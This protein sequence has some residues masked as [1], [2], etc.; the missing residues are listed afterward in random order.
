[1]IAVED[2]KQLIQ[3]VEAA[4]SAN[5]LL[6]TVETLA[7][8]RHEAAI[9]TLIAILGYNN[10]GAAVAAVEGLVDLGEASVPPL[11]KQ[12]DGYNYGARAW[13]IRAL[14]GIGDARALSL[15]LEAASQDFSFSVRRAAAKGLGNIRWEQLSPDAILKAQEQI[16]ETLLQVMGDSEWVVRY[17]AVLALQSFAKTRA[18]MREPV[19]AKF[20]ELRETEPELAVRARLQLGLQELNGHQPSVSE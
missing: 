13:A 9:P 6:E 10:P 7:A 17:A 3:A 14:A 20:Q 8:A 19:L 18:Q 2:I 5:S 12:I 11:L 15:L 16:L 4:D 1:M